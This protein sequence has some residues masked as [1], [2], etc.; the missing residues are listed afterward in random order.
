MTTRTPAIRR[1]TFSLRRIFLTPLLLGIV[2]T[3]GLIFALVGDNWWD[4][5][6]WFALAIPIAVTVWYIRP[7]RWT[8][9][10]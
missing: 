6:S 9:V 1:K 4:V 10:V 5:V 3:G 8:L 2:T 7:G